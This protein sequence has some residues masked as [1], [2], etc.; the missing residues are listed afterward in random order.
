MCHSL[1]HAV[2]THG[3]ACVL[4]CYSLAM[5]RRLLLL[6]VLPAI[7]RADELLHAGPLH[8]WSELRSTAIWV[9]TERAA[10]V[11]LRY[12]PAA[13]RAAGGATVR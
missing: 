4:L 7:A 3:A 1:P 6:L 12:H 9:Q 11:Q 13:A 8:A 10:D 5:C 2:L